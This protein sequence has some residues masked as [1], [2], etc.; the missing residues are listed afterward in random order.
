[1]LEEVPADSRPALYCIPE[2]RYAKSSLYPID[3]PDERRNTLPWVTQSQGSRQKNVLTIECAEMAC[4]TLFT[5]STLNY[6]NQ[7]FFPS[8]LI[9][10]A[11]VSRYDESYGSST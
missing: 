1:M 10:L 9:K 2:V 8:C 7:F 5:G 3:H 4:I 11:N 6:D